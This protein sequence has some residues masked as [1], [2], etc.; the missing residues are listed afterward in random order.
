MNRLPASTGWLW[1][2]QGFGLFRKQPGFLILLLFPQILF[3]MLTL[4]FAQPIG[5]IAYVLLMPSF[6]MV[7]FEASRI[8]SLDQ[9]LT[10]AV[11]LTGFRKGALGPLTKLGGIYLAMMVVL[12]LMM[13]PFLD[14][15]AIVQAFEAAQKT[16]KD[17]VLPESMMQL[18]MG[19]ALIAAAIMFILSFAAPLIHW[20][21]MP[22]FKAMFYSVAAMF[23]SFVPV[24][25]LLLS[26]GLIWV[27]IMSLGTAIFGKTGAVYVLTWIHMVMLV[28]FQC[29]VYAAYRQL[30]PGDAA[31]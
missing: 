21:K 18:M 10:P 25:V 9:K 23:G 8:L 2:K 30:I 15:D 20:K 17:L 19:F 31:E 11:I 5:S 22:T 4:N 3:T 26:W 14:K 7:I 27:T 28:I 6:S 16:K 24:L 13:L 29:A 12:L 1:L